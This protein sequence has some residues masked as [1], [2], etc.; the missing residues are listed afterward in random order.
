LG[1]IINE[2]WSHVQEIRAG[3]GKDRATFNR[4][5]AFCKS[6]N[7]TLGTKGR[8]LRCL[9]R[10]PLWCRTF[11]ENTAKKLNAF[12]MWLRRLLEIPWTTKVT[13]VRVLRTMKK[14]LELMNIIKARKLEYLGHVM[15][16]KNNLTRKNPWTK[17]TRTTQDI[18]VVKNL[19][20]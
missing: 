10:S 2:D 13:N 8:L 12:D 4:M 18:V 16:N 17:R 20:T 5:S 9:L 11:N 14:D 15:R 3:I 6:H 19:R 1:T 7:I